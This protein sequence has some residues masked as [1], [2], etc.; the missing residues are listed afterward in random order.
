MQN[1][2]L[3]L[4][5]F[6][7]L[8]A[9]QFH[10][11]AEP[12][13]EKYKTYKG[14]IIFF[15]ISKKEYE[16]G[17]KL[18]NI[19]L[20][21]LKKENKHYLVYGVPYHTAVGK[22]EILVKNT[23]SNKKFKFTVLEKDFN[24]QFIRIKKK[25]TSPSD[26]QI[27]RISKEKNIIGKYRNLWTN[28]KPDIKFI[29]PADGVVTGVFG[30]RRFYNGIEGNYHN[31]Y[32]I[33]GRETDYVLAPSHGEVILVGDFFYNGKFVYINHGSG[34][35]SIFL[36]LSKIHVKQGDTVSKGH[37][38]CQIGSTGASTGPHLHWS[39][40]LNQTYVNPELFLHY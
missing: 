7:L 14:D 2:Y 16:L 36:H 12:A 37:V 27:I 9:Y 17:Y 15:E 6:V 3:K 38:I 22:H 30:T 19:S 10:I 1:Y 33:A 5:I 29:K 40:T 20:L 35:K 28:N 39:V 26:E 23:L 11:Y 8:S 34:L 21:V 18:N 13:N 32:D 24:K 31:G 4:I 25:Y